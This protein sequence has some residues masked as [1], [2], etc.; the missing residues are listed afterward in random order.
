MMMFVATASA[1]NADEPGSLVIIET[2][3]ARAAAGVKVR[4]ILD[5]DEPAAPYK[6]GIINHPLVKRLGDAGI[7]VKLDTPSILLHSKFF[8]V[9]EAAVVL[10][11]H[12]LTKASMTETHEVSVLLE[13]STPAKAFA[14][15]FDT[16][17]T[18][19]P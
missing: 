3:E 15:R 14:Q 13:G 8:V 12:N 6:S 1:G 18:S 4:V 10:G 5:Q 19:L 9:D 17:W 2:L 7:T 11:S 16:L